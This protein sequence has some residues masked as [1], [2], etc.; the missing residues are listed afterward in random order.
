MRAVGFS[1]LSKDAKDY[2]PEYRV[3]LAPASDDMVV[4]SRDAVGLMGTSSHDRHIKGAFVPRT[5]SLLEA[6][7]TMRVRWPLI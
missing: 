1:Q 3:F 7:S 5:P 4:D 6:G 2:A